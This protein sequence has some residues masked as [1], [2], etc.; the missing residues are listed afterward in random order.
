MLRGIRF[1][2][3]IALVFLVSAAAFGQTTVNV[4]PGDDLQAAL[5]AAG[6]G[7]TVVFAAGWYDVVPTDA[8]QREAIHVTASLRGITLRGA[9]PG[10]DPAT[11]TILDG[12]AGFLE[13]GILLE[14]SGVT[15][16]GLTLVNFWNRGF[17]LGDRVTNI[18]C[19]RCWVLG[20]ESGV[21]T[22]GSAGVW[23]QGTPEIFANMVR[24][25]YCILARGGNDG[26][27]IGS[28]SAILFDHCDFY[29]MDS[30]LLVSE[31]TSVVLARNCI[32]N[33]GLNSDNIQGNAASLIHAKNSVFF[34]PEG[35]QTDDLGGMDFTGF[36]YAV[37]SIGGD[38][39]YL[40]VGPDVPFLQLDFRLRSGSPALTAGKDENG[41]S[42]FAG[43]MGGAQ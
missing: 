15:V 42:T 2:G 41:N 1:I 7:G 32:F 9:G 27:V 3:W 23:N 28:G 6:Q 36:V 13:T 29:D 11:A 19:R 20:C 12:E 24:F 26:G 5:L 16:E 25:K 43:S 14:A 10:V 37:D 39:L 40:N 18:E 30:A 4:S 8:E 17:L 21:T 34:D 22:D 33:A 38:P 31:D 35:G